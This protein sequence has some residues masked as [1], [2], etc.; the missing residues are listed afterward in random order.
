MT[1]S[2]HLPRAKEAA[3]GRWADILA[4]AGLSDKALSGRNGPCPICGGKDRFRWAKARELWVC[5]NCT[6]SKY[7]GPMDLLMR[8]LGLEFKEA[9]EWVESHLGVRDPHRTAP[10][11]ATRQAPAAHPHELSQS[12][13]ESRLNRMQQIWNE[14]VPITVGD[15]VH[16]YLSTRVPGCRP[17]DLC[18][19][20]YHP[21]LPYWDTAGDKP[22]LLGRYP[23]MIAKAVDADGRLLQ[24]HKTYLSSD[25]KKADVPIVKKT[26][27]GVG[28]IDFFVP[29]FPPGEDVE[30]GIAEG[31]ESAIAAQL[32]LGIPVWPCLS[33]PSLA[34]F[35]VPHRL[36]DRVKRVHIVGDNDTPKTRTVDGKSRTYRPGSQYAQDA[37]TNVARQGFRTR[38]VMPARTGYDLADYHQQANA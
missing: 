19:L 6:E 12:D 15:P 2:G 7:A 14:T 37:A 4:H 9:A 31:I 20:R 25:G 17:E 3:A 13:I 8:L 35:T 16:Q 34:R 5:N 23:A 29:L 24:L 38:I 27:R 18:C 10:A 1:T 26:D 21:C 22:V 28:R 32:Q 30:L 33:G 36:A 11:P